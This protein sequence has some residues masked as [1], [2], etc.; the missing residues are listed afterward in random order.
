MRETGKVAH[1]VF[2]LFA[3]Q[4]KK[5]VTS[6]LRPVLMTIMTTVSMFPLALGYDKVAVLVRILRVHAEQQNPEFKKLRDDGMGWRHNLP[7]G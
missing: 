1:R 7:F 5:Q 3:T 6:C 2:K 4:F